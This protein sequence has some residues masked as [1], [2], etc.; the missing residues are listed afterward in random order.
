MPH[1]KDH[2]EPS[3]QVI[4]HLPNTDPTKDPWTGAA[5][6]QGRNL[7][8]DTPIDENVSLMPALGKTPAEMGSELSPPINA[9][10]IVI[11]R[12]AADQPILQ[13]SM[14]DLVILMTAAA[15]ALGAVRILPP[16]LFALVAGAVTLVFLFIAHE[17]PIS[18]TRLRTIT[19]GL[20]TI[21]LFAMLGAIL[22]TAWAG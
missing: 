2:I 12:E 11:E 10:D 7:S 9:D 19:I 22:Q 15:G 21:Y 5:I 6:E 14:W 3:R 8:D 13:F 18:T 20:V 1:R 4:M 16:V 17:Q